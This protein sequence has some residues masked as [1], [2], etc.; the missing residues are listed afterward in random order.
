VFFALSSWELA[1]V[2]AGIIFGATLVGLVAGRSL[3]RHAE[4][5]REPLG[6][7]QGAL[8]TLV[9]LVL[10]FGLAMAVG[11]Y[12]ARRTAVVNDA[13][14]IGTAYLRAQ[15]LREPV[16]SES[17]PLYARYTDASIRLSNSAPGSAAAK[18]AI[19]EESVLQRR[20]W[21]LAGRALDDQPTQSAPRL[22]VESLNEMI[23]MQTTRVSALNN[24]VPSAIL[25]IEVIGAATALGLMALYLALLSRGVVSV[26]LAA[27]LVTLLLFVSF[28]LDR[29]TRGFITIPT[30]PLVGLRASMELPPAAAAPTDPPG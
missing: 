3:S 29:P 17:L 8:L 19:A 4:T 26:L 27:G 23:D 15:T 22:Y 13:N 18:S 6:I 20:L 25:L 1:L 14:T 21:G 11:R 7:V 12:D 9:G 10:A 5:L 28:D 16:R 30:A 24:R 2:L